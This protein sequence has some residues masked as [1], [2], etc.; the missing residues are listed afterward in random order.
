M[1]PWGFRENPDCGGNNDAVR[2]QLNAEVHYICSNKFDRAALM[3]DGSL[4]T[5]E[6]PS[7][8]GDSD[9]ATAR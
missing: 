7:S 6:D 5:W 8:G 3:E 9:A 2:E 1:A 4:E